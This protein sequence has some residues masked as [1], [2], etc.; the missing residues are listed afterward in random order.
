MRT[1]HQ[2]L[3]LVHAMRLSASQLLYLHT[4]SPA[5]LSLLKHKGNLI[6]YD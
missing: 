4:N 2:L 3:V 6:I 5:A 1:H